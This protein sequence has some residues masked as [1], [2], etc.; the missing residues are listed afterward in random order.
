[1]NNCE[2]TTFKSEVKLKCVNNCKSTDERG[3]FM[4]VTNLVHNLRFNLDV[5]HISLASAKF[6]KYDGYQI[7]IYVTIFDG[8]YKNNEKR[9]SNN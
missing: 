9:V 3:K 2:L 8:Y 6:E 1:M 7:D 5:Y 4:K